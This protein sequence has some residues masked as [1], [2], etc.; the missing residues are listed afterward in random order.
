MH[1]TSGFRHS[2]VALV[3]GAGLFL[4]ASHAEA[5]IA[6]SGPVS[7]AVPLTSAGVFLN[8]VTGANSTAAESVLGW[9]INLWG[10]AGLGLGFSSPFGP[11]APFLGGFVLGAGSS[12]ANLAGG[13]SISAAN[14]YGNAP[15]TAPFTQWSL[16]SNNNYFGF[17]FTNEPGGTL[18][19][20]WGRLAIG[21]TIQSRSIVGYAY[22]NVANTAIVAGAI[23]EPGTYALMGLGVAGL[24]VAVRRR[25]QV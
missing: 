20:G 1:M 2:M 15:S 6:W 5:V 12:V 19:Y 11:S 9:D 4:T 18:H 17:R 24:I 22:E 14:F 16:N 10:A 21:A 25:K 8:V 13:T 23:P 7:I 3:A